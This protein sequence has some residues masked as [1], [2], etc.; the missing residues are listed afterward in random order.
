MGWGDEIIV[1]G[2][3]RRMQRANPLPVRV[4]DVKGR[5]RWSEIWDHNPR[6]ARPEHRGP[7]QFCTSSSGRRGYIAGKERGGWVWRNWVCP[8]GEIYLTDEEKSFGVRHSAKVILEPSIKPEASPNKDWGWSRWCEVS[9]NLGS[10]GFSVAHFA[11]R[12]GRVLPGAEVIRAKNFRHACAVVSKARLAIL[13]EGGL[14]H[15]AAA[16]GTAAIVIFGGYISP[17]Q[18]G[19]AHHLNLFSGG[20]PCGRRSPCPHCTEA[21]KKITP[22]VVCD[23]AT[24][25][26]RVIRFD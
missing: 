25:L 24:S 20:I 4:V 19:Y 3:A 14:H 26:L 12:N 15:A 16:L 7:V 1:S 6:L 23:H 5:T 17:N 21:M 8:I 9:K 2:I 13:P 11:M 10:L 22:E 18:T